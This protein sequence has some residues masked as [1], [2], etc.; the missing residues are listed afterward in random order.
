MTCWYIPNQGEKM[1]EASIQ[2]ILSTL[3]N[4]KPIASLVSGDT[5]R[6]CRGCVIDSR[7][8]Q[9]DAIFVAFPGERVDGNDFARAAIEAGAGAV[10]LT[11][12][13]DPELI[14]CAEH[15]GCAVLT[16]ACGEDFLLG[17]AH[18]W[19]TKLG[20]TVVGVTGSVGKT[21]TKDMLAAVL[22]TT[23]RVHATN[24]NFNNLIGMP[25]TILSAPRDTQV[26][27][28]EMG[29][30]SRGEIE[31]LSRCAQ[32]NIATITKIGTSHIGMLG[33]RENI[34]RA[35][36]EITCGMQGT[37]PS[38]DAPVPGESALLVLPAE[39]DFL[40][41]MMAHLFDYGTEVKAVTVG[42]HEDCAY[43]MGEVALDAEG[44]PHFT[45][46]LADGT[47]FAVALPVT[48]AQ[49]ALDAML[50]IGV[51]DTLGVNA[52][53]IVHGLSNLN[54]TGRRQ[55]SRSARDGARIIDDTYNASPES[56]AAALDLLT[57][58]PAEGSRIAVLG[59]IAELGD[60]TARLHALVGAYAAAKKLD[61]LAC[62]GHE[63]A[64]EMAEAARLMGMA[65]DAVLELPNAE[66][67]I[68][69]LRGVFTE[70]N[71]V[72]VKA[73][74]CVELDRLVEEVC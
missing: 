32:P 7:Q 1:V 2:D 13:P 37:S 59:E 62:V 66:E 33:S 49:S 18:A 36:M 23:Y 28:L 71:V 70:G 67:A 45:A 35:K 50:A 74:R 56:M 65:E 61:Y 64:H 8:V 6:V 46:K 52:G 34:A 27:V 24:G 40:P 48:G 10:A 22:G 5:G 63:G 30:N 60:E 31:Q 53:R 19:R 55:E 15:H 72:L 42:G 38:C 54:I 58:L 11:R 41:F 69:R 3:W 4:S 12:T 16:I 25:L 51:A 39:D 73:S 44:K 14:A 47:E 9:Q 43:R 17:L 29:M 20:C 57:L 26:L 68:A 21:T